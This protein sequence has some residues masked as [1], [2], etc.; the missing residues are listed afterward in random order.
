MELLR[1]IRYI[2]PTSG[3]SR[4]ILFD[5][6]EISNAT[7]YSGSLFAKAGGK[8]WID[9]LGLMSA[10]NAKFNL[11]NGTVTGI[12]AGATATILHIVM[13]GINVQLLL[14]VILRTGYIGAV[15]INSDTDNTITANGTD[16]VY[17][18]GLQA[19]AGAYA[20]F[21]HSYNYG[22]CNKM[23]MNVLSQVQ[24]H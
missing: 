11:S 22:K 15:L 19:E 20:N 14:Q 1:L 6:C 18:W 3:S 8:S 13:D 5:I 23:K 9:C 16:G 12:S 7:S 24:L 21:I 4:Q 10:E 2:L 17:F